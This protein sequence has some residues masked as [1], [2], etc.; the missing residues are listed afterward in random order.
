MPEI[1]NPVLAEMYRTGKTRAADG[2]EVSLN[3]Q[4]SP[5]YT[6]ALY[7]AVLDRR[8]DVALEIGMAHGASTLA[9]LTALRN[10]GCGRLVSVDPCQHTLFE[11][12]GVESVRRAGLA[13][14]HRLMDTY[15]YLALPRLLEEGCK[16]D[17]AYIDGWH[18]FDYALLDFFYIDKMLRPGGVVGFNDCGYR[19]VARVLRFVTSHRRYRPYDAGLKRNFRARNP[20]L[21]LARRV[22]NF[23]QEDRY[24]QKVEDWEP[25]WH[26]YARF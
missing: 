17:F 12:A 1:P 19:A 25:P 16:I 26:F 4:V 11:G 2:R 10:A 14:R 23:S 9:I 24:F 13:D 6:R 15:D 20:L 22:L 7:R 3:A 5:E 8:P 21:S 18:T